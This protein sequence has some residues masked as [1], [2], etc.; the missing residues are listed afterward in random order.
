V[1]ESDREAVENA[2][3]CIGLT[4]PEQARVVRIRSTLVLGEIE[5]SEALLP[6]IAKRPDLE[7][8]GRGRPLPFDAAGRIV[9]LLAH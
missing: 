3:N 5:C 7:V 4:P 6:E 8:V 9:P 2:L 1:F